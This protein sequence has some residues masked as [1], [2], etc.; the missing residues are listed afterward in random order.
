MLSDIDLFLVG[1]LNVLDTLKKMKEDG[2]DLNNIQFNYIIKKELEKLSDG[3]NFQISLGRLSTFQTLKESTKIGDDL[4]LIDLEKQIE[5]NLR[6]IDDEELAKGATSLTGFKLMLNDP[7]SNDSE[8]T[9]VK[10][11]P[12]KLIL[13]LEKCERLLDSLLREKYAAHT[14]LP[15]EFPKQFDDAEKTRL[16]ENPNFARHEFDDAIEFM[17]LDAKLYILSK[18]KKEWNEIPKYVVESFFQI[19]D[20]LNSTPKFSDDDLEKEMAFDTMLLGTI[21]CKKIIDFFEKFNSR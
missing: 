15:D 8:N 17:T 10:Y 18:K 20:I 19:K 6:E 16:N 7:V 3:I 4:N 14:R 5:Q 13:D 2:S 12:S 9:T 11:L 1:K 21:F